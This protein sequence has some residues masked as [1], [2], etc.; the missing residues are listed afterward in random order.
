MKRGSAKVSLVIDA[1]N[2][3]SNE[4][5]AKRMDA[6]E[7]TRK[8][9]VNFLTATKRNKVVNE[10]TRGIKNGIKFKGAIPKTK[11]ATAP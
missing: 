11:D 2:I 8:F 4:A 7:A 9:P 1:V 3:A 6:T 10:P 5:T